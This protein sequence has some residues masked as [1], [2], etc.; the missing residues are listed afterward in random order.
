MIFCCVSCKPLELYY[1]PCNGLQL[2]Q[3]NN[4]SLN[5][6]VQHQGYRGSV[7]LTQ[8]KVECYNRI[9]YYAAMS[10]CYSILL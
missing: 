5:Q 6:N 7:G 4:C 10:S 8:V 2:T 1:V 9:Y 3:Q